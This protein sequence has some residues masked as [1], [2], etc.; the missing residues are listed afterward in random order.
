MRPWYESVIITVRNYF[1]FGSQFLLSSFLPSISF[2]YGIGKAERGSDMEFK[3]NILNYIF[4]ISL[5][6]EPLQFFNLIANI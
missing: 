6:F 3:C 4:F 1:Y 2:I 5:N